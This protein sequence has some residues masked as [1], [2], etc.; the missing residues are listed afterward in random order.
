MIAFYLIRSSPRCRFPIYLNRSPFSQFCAAQ[1]ESVPVAARPVV[2]ISGWRGER[3]VSHLVPHLSVSMVID[4]V[5]Y[6]L[7]SEPMRLSDCD[8]VARRVLIA[9]APSGARSSCG[10]GPLPTTLPWPIRMATHSLSVP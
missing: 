5:H 4:I 7:Q 1:G 10:L 9:R 3:V 6:D 8:S 2:V